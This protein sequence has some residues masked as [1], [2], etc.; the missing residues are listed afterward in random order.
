VPG[1]VIVPGHGHVCEQPAK[2]RGISPPAQTASATNANVIVRRVVPT[3]T[4][5]NV[6]GVDEGSVAGHLAG[7]GLTTGTVTRVA[8]VSGHA[9]AA[10]PTGPAEPV[11]AGAT[12]VES[13]ISGM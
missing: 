9:A 11:A 7:S 3:T 8:A 4:M 2:L 12:R 5:P 13:V 10:G 6:I 1:P